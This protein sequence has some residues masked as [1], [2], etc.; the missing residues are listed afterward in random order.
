MDPHDTTPDRPR[1]RARLAAVLG[2][3]ALAIPGGLIASTAFA[4]DRSTDGGS[5]TAPI[6]QSESPSAPAQEERPD[7]RDCP[8]K[9][10]DGANGSGQSGESTAPSTGA[11][12]TAL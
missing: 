12:T 4:A 8:E 7:G 2:V 9:D 10:G 11:E 3:A 5:T 1:G 6:Q